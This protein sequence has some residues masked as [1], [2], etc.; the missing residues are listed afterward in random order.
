[1]W[2]HPSHH[3]WPNAN[4]VFKNTSELSHSQAENEENDEGID[5]KLMESMI[6]SEGN[7]IP[8]RLLSM[9]SSVCS[10]SNDCE[11]LLSEEHT[12]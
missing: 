6:V 4:V 8:D 9:K 2:Q 10:I 5:E 12:L 11:Q 3:L 7:D 1:M